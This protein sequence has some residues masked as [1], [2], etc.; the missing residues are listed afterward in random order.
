[1]EPTV[2]IEKIKTF[3]KNNKKIAYPLEYISNADMRTIH[4]AIAEGEDR[5]FISDIEFYFGVYVE[6]EIQPKK[7]VLNYIN[8]ERGVKVRSGTL[9]E[10]T[11]RIQKKLRAHLRL[12]NPLRD[13]L[14]KRVKKKDE[15][16]HVLTKTGVQKPEKTEVMYE[17]GSQDLR[18]KVVKGIDEGTLYTISQEP[19]IIGRGNPKNHQDIKLHD[20]SISKEH[21]RIEVVDGSIYIVD[22]KSTNGTYVNDTIITKQKITV[23]DRILIGQTELQVIVEKNTNEDIDSETVYIKGPMKRV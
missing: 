19:M 21:A 1:M 15:K 5:A 6:P 7:V 4:L 2:L 22:L 12:S 20:K 13:L 18:L 3:L 14:D 17:E 9:S 10:K 8:E 11:F 23:G 16:P